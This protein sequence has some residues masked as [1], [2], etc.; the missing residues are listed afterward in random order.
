MD[1]EHMGNGL[2]KTA[3]PAG[4]VG[5]I[6]PPLFLLHT[7]RGVGSVTRVREGIICKNS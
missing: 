2:E 3:R 7:V 5:R 4:T 6:L 1:P